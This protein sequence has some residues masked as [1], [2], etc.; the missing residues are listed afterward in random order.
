MNNI[1]YLICY[2]EAEERCVI[3]EKSGRQCH[4]ASVS[5]QRVRFFAYQT[6]FERKYLYCQMK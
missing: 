1:N 6:G 5:G 2:A 4:G 3:L